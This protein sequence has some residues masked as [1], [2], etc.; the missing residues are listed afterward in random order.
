VPFE[1]DRVTLADAVGQA[2]GLLDL[3]ADATGVFVFRYE[4]PQYFQAIEQMTPQDLGLPN[5][6]AAGVPVVYQ[7]DFKDPRGFFAAQRFLMRDD[8]VLYVSNA[9]G[10]DL[11][12]L[13]S[14]FSGSVSSAAAATTLQQ[15]LLEE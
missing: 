13:L 6:T 2:G 11:Q 12:K 15:R 9:T 5:A 4:D 3:R 1:A 14:I 7:L 10:T 8:D